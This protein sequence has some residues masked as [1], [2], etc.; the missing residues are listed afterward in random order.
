M[1]RFKNIFFL[2]SL[3]TIAGGCNDSSLHELSL[4]EDSVIT[5]SV[6]SEIIV[7]STYSDYYWLEKEK[8]PIQ[9]IEGK[10]KIMYY[11]SDTDILTKK[12][13]KANTEFKGVEEWNNCV[14]PNTKGANSNTMKFVDLKVATIQ[15]NYDDVSSVL[16][17]SFYWAPYYKME[18]GN[19]IGISNL[20]YVKLKP[21]TTL[22]ILKDF[23]KENAVEF[24]GPDD[25]L[26]KLYYLA[27]TNLSKG[28][29][30]EMANLFYESGL[31][32]FASP[33]LSGAGSLDCINEPLFE[34]GALW[35]LGNNSTSSIARINYCESRTIISQGSSNVIVGII[36]SGVD[37]NHRDLYNVLPGW[38]ATTQTTP[39]RVS[40]SHGTMV[41]GFIGATPNNSQDVAGV[42]YG[43]TILP[44][45]FM[46]NSAGQI[47]ST[48]TQMV[49]AIEYAVNSGAKVINCSWQFKSASIGSAIKNALDNDCVVVFASGNG[50]E[51]I[52]YPANSDGRII[53]VGA[54]NKNGNK[55][56]FSNY[57][58]QLDVVAPGE[59]VYSLS[60][61]NTTA[62]GSGT[63]Y[64]AP[65]V[66]GVAAMILSKY[67]T[68]TASK[69]RYRI[70]KT[71]K[72]ITAPAPYTYQTLASFSSSNVYMGYGLLDA[73][74]AL[75]PQ[76][77]YLLD[78]SITNS[79]NH[80]PMEAY[81]IEL[82]N[83][84]WSP[85]R[86]LIEIYP[87]FETLLTGEQF[88]ARYDLLPGSY[89]A[90]V[91]AE[92]DDIYEDF[93][94]EFVDGGRINFTYLGGTDGPL[95]WGEPTNTLY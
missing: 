13:A 64:A 5:R 15:G 4:I 16:S 36:D 62:M 48:D 94:F 9:E 92:M 8:I 29:A 53:V 70:E 67:P 68:L 73:Y 34:S 51:A 75:A 3:A 2:L 76:I 89:Y 11:S 28:N 47:T 14:Y 41:A 17:E 33:S 74:A 6:D 72:K 58:S 79:S 82:Y 60:P 69:V 45:S 84:D 50:G 31:F 20:F 18:D 77:P 59:N 93:R 32:E 81:H 27:C 49:R 7:D 1:I 42:A 57:G 10:Y 19:E 90:T 25:F 39:N 65:Q 21:E 23:A 26:K 46:V 44:I 22:S 83:T 80:R 88:T 54:I 43:A 37:I 95:R 30:L 71:A 12:A 52:S 40:H 61:G 63:S 91:V 87:G 56:S 35:H 24:I 85:I 38:D 78:I 66:A 86:D 55:A